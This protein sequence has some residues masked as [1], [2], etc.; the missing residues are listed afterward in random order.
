MRKGKIL[1]ARLGRE[2]NCSSGMVPM[3]MLILGGGG[4][5]LLVLGASIAQAIGHHKS[6]STGKLSKRYLLI[7]LVFG[8]VI[9]TG[10]GLW[11]YPMS[12]SRADE[13]TIIV[14]GLGLA[15]WYSLAVVAGYRL[16][17]RVRYWICLLVPLLFALGT[18]ISA[19]VAFYLAF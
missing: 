17:S 13:A 12:Y 5:L 19:V 8:L 10:L 2:A 9:V 16:A 18:A 7:P 6:A 14:L 15:T 3:F 11:F 4:S 1:K